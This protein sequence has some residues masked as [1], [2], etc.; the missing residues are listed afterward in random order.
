MAEADFTVQATMTTWTRADLIRHLGEVLLSAATGSP[1]TAT[2][3]PLGAQPASIR[4]F[5]STAPLTSQTTL[6]VTLVYLD[7]VYATG[8]FCQQPDSY[9]EFL[10]LGRLHTSFVA[11]GQESWSG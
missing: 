10:I 7:D 9:V 4:P 6:R 2:R 5:H 11:S 3:Q 1:H 8:T